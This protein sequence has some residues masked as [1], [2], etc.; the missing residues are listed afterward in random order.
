MRRRKLT[1][2]LRFLHVSLIIGCT[3]RSIKGSSKLVVY[4][5]CPSRF[6]HVWY[7]RIFGFP[8]SFN[9]ELIDSAC[10]TK[11]STSRHKH[12]AARFVQYLSST[13]Y[14]PANVIWYFLVPSLLESCHCRNYVLFFLRNMLFSPVVGNRLNQFCLPASGRA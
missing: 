5:S 8:E 9:G 6:Q 3:R 14:S 11:A 7:S 12:V 10:S 1:G 2:R 13:S 4:E